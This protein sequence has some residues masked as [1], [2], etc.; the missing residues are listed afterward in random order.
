MKA[1]T[2]LYS[3]TLVNGVRRAFSSVPRLI[4]L[5][6]FVGY[7]LMWLPRAFGG[8]TPT[9]GRLDAL[10]QIP[11]PPAEVVEAFVFAAMAG[12]LVLLGTNLFSLKGGF[13]PADVDVLFPTPVD[14]RAV[15]AYRMAR[16]TLLTLVVPLLLVL[17]AYR[18]ASAGYEALF[19]QFENPS[20]GPTALKWLTAGYMLVSL[21]WVALSYAAG[22]WMNR[23]GEKDR[24]RRVAPWLLVGLVIGVL[25]LAV[26][27][28]RA[29][30]LPGFVSAM[31][32][33]ELRAVLFL[34]AAATEL[35]LAPLTGNWIG[36]ALGLGVLV[37][38]IGLGVG[39]AMRQAQWLYEESALNAGT[40]GLRLKAR[41][42]DATGIAGDMAAQGKLRRRNLGWISRLE[43]RGALAITWA[44]SLLLLRSMLPT[45]LIFGAMSLIPAVAI[46]AL[47]Q[48]MPERVGTVML[49][50]LLSFAFPGVAAV[51]QAGFMDTLRRVD[52]LKP[53]PYPLTKVVAA[54]VSSKALVGMAPSVAGVLAFLLAAPALAQEVGALLVVLP[55]FAFGMAAVQF[56]VIVLLPDL[57]DP[58]QRTFRGLV[59]LIGLVSFAAPPAAVFGL[60]RFLK[61]PAL[62]AGAVSAVPMLLL[63]WLAVLLGARLLADYN[64][65]D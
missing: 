17:L 62:A 18:P 10:A 24:S 59:N 7:Y 25:G 49:F 22:L 63:A 32:A 31:H 21:A 39:L 26:W 61:V 19:R 2:F 28:V 5:L 40:Q 16:D 9:P 60:L 37:G 56:V 23:P 30:G 47:G 55:A 27:R 46:Q 51:S 6:F 11:V 58:S 42:G 4:G 44:G 41:A 15:L 52:L 57:D 29:G 50:M 12:L 14:P 65:S 64:P 20:A 3:R 33:P 53:M 8:S 48:E 1:L 54:D 34:P 45:L 38:S 43:P 13:R 35:A 36:F